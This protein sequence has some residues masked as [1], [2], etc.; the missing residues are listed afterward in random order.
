MVVTYKA[1]IVDPIQCFTC[2]L[3]FQTPKWFRNNSSS[4]S[5]GALG[6]GD[7]EPEQDCCDPAQVGNDG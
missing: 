2:F 4:T 7:L 6:A 1:R 5:P 3:T